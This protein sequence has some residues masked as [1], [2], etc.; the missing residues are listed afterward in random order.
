MSLIFV[1]VMGAAIANKTVHEI[2]GQSRA[3][4]T[5]TP[6][7]V[8]QV[9]ASTNTTSSTSSSGLSGGTNS[10]TVEPAG[11]VVS[12]PPSLPA[13]DQALVAKGE[14]FYKKLKQDNPDAAML[15]DH[16]LAPRTIDISM[17]G[18]LGGHATLDLAMPTGV[19]NKLNQDDKDAL[20]ALLQSKIK[21]ARDHPENYAFTK[22]EAPAY[23]PELENIRQVRDGAWE[24]RTGHLDNEGYLVG[25]SPVLKGSDSDNLPSTGLHFVYANAKDDPVYNSLWDGAVQQ[26]ATYLSKTLNDADSVKYTEWTKVIKTGT[27]YR[28]SVTYRAK[29]SFGAYVLKDQTYVF[30][31]NGA[32]TQITDNH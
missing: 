24:I 8:A 2:A 10:L 14:A 11:T 3:P 19:W 16:D 13:L 31:R 21:D 25:D 26:V 23:L 29:N 4:Q 27:G 20:V 17:I 9:L 12:T 7:N 22:P 1:V 32:I 18:T 30:D 5:N 28:V 6:G 15:P